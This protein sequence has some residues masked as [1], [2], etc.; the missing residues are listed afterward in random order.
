MKNTQEISL[1]EKVFALREANPNITSQTART[2]L[3]V[4]Q[5][6]LD[7][8]RV[9]EREKICDAFDIGSGM[10]GDIFGKKQ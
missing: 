8:S 5:K 3:G 4:T 7:E 2:L 10:F 1:A 6:E 9:K